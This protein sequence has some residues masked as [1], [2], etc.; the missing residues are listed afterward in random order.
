MK[1]IFIS[2]IGTGIGKTL[3]SAV[4]AEAL[5]ADYWK[6]V[7]AGLEP[8]TDRSRMKALISNTKTIVH[9]ET[10]IF[11]LP[12]S[13]HISARAENISISLSRIV[14]DYRRM[15]QSRPLIIEGAGGLKV[16]LNEN[17][18]VID[19]VKQLDARLVLVS[20]NYLGSINHSLM[21]A[22]VCRSRGLDVAGW[23]F[24]DQY[25]DYAAE[26]AG[27]SGFPILFSLPALNPIS[28]ET[29]AETGKRF[30]G[31]CRKALLPASADA[32]E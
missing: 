19:L 5:Q 8:E 26:I 32:R 6:P 12:A 20:R 1:P 2:G 10:Y 17:E 7:Q 9:P 28:K 11:S 18:F 30:A 14:E 29:I 21:T 22:A 27:W 24:N 31:P 25:M 4:I 16:P 23:V 13:P 15:D 3:I